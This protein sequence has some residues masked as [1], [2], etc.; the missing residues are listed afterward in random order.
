MSSHMI[1][2][3]DLFS[4]ESSE[5]NFCLKTEFLSVKNALENVVCKCQLFCSGLNVSLKDRVRL[6]SGEISLDSWEKEMNLKK[7]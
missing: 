7:S 6:E 2:N 5:T 3:A 1:A 4:I